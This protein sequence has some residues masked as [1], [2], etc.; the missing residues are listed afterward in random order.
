M[1]ELNFGIAFLWA[2]AGREV[3]GL[4]LRCKSPSTAQHSVRAGRQGSPPPWE[5]C[6]QLMQLG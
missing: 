4:N 5:G 6:S 2:G 3:K 1:V